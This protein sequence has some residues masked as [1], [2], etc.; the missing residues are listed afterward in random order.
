MD[1]DAQEHAAHHLFLVIGIQRSMVEEAR[2]L[3][4]AIRAW[5]DWTFIGAR[6]RAAQLNLLRDLPLPEV[7]RR[8]IAILLG[9][10]GR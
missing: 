4:R 6:R 3:V 7:I 2:A 1:M 5:L 8:V 9:D 10:Q